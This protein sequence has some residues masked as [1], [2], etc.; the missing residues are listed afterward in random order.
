MTIAQADCRIELRDR[1]LMNTNK[2]AIALLLLHLALTAGM[3]ACT[4]VVG[5]D[6]WRSLDEEAMALYDKG[7]YD[8]AVVMEKKALQLA[9]VAL[10]DR[11]P[12]FGILLNNLGLQYEALGQFSLAVTHYKRSLAI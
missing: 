1:K 8:R 4:Q 9:E 3:S 5:S 10:G 7:Q 11:H 2:L 6:T 12:Y